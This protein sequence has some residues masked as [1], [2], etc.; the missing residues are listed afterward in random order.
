MGYEIVLKG[1]RILILS[2][3]FAPEIGSAANRMTN[4]TTQLIKLGY[5][6]DI[7]TSEPTYPDKKLYKDKKFFDDERLKFIEK[8]SKLIRVKTIEK[9]RTQSFWT[10]L[11][12]YLSSLMRFI[13]A[14]FLLEGKYD[15]VIATVPTP[16]MVIVGWIAKLKFKSKL[17]M[18]IRDLWPECIKNVGIFRQSKF[19]LK[20]AY[21]LER[22][23]LKMTDAIVI[24]SN[25]FRGYLEKIG[26]KK[27]IVF[28][29]NGFTEK[30]FDIND[31]LRRVEKNKKF[32]VIYT[33]M[34]GLA[35]N[36][37]CIVKVANYFRNNKDIEFKI[38][39]TGV[40]RFKVLELIEHYKIKN[41]HVIDPMPKK[42]TL[43]EVAKSHIAIAHLR[44]DSAFD[45]VIPGKII[46]YMGVGT[47]IVAGVSGYTATIVKESQSGVVVE[48]DD[49]KDMAIKIKELYKDRKA[50]DKHAYRA[51]KFCNKV[52]SWEKNIYELD[53]L[54]KGLMKDEV[55]EEKS[56]PDGMESLH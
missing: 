17:I 55:N 9:E 43:E 50:L 13:S 5:K 12:I 37:N 34:I 53:D 39:G 35:Q 48:P 3:V 33:G 49:Y 47:P 6:V 52:F 18:D 31:S 21:I 36:V 46:D 16:F 38:I 8:N 26:Y 15:I 22:I 32:T 27:K 20:L 24:N 10:R 40:L 4:I 25:G 30:E 29:P 28:I 54:I 2:E 19:A 14:C 51:N 42:E 23:I 44:G 11:H 56:V 7:V 45:L 41:I 1:K